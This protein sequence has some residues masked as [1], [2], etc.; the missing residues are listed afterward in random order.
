MKRASTLP[1]HDLRTIVEN[2]Q[3]ILWPGG[4]PNAEWGPDELEAIGNLL[5]HFG[6]SPRLVAARRRRK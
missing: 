2:V 5:H 1:V 4:N 6:L 3:T